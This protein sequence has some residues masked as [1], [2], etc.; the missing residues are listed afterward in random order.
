M[1][2]VCEKKPDSKHDFRKDA[3]KLSYE[4]NW[5][6]DKIEG[7]GILTYLNGNRYSGEW[8]DGKI[9]GQGEFT[10][11]DGSKYEGKW[12]ENKRNGKGKLTFSKDDSMITFYYKMKDNAVYRSNNSIISIICAEAEKVWSKADGFKGEYTSELIDP[13]ED[14]HTKDS[15]KASLYFYENKQWWNDKYYFAFAGHEIS[16]E[17][18]DDYPTGVVDIQNLRQGEFDL[19]TFSFKIGFRFKF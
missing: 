10:W 7:E 4:G 13:V 17:E 3:L 16:P 2:M 14:T 8:K 1:D 12:K 6:N 5:L 11:A 18:P 19:S 9:H 15:G